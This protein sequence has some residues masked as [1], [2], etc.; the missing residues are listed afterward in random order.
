MNNLS[1]R[2]IEHS[3]DAG[4]RAVTLENEWLSVTVLPDKGA[5]IYRFVYKP[6][7]LDVLWK[8]PWG[9][10]PL[11]QGFQT[12]SSSEEAWLENYEGGWQEIFPNGGDACFYKGCHLNF[13]GEVS[14]LPWSYSLESS[15]GVASA[16]FYVSTFRSPFQMQ[17][18]LVLEKG[19]PLL[20]I[21]E[22]VTNIAEEEMHF[23]WGHHPAFGGEFLGSD[24]TIQL[25]GAVY[26]NHHVET[27]EL[28]RIAAGTVAPWPLI[29]GKREMVDLS[30]V[31]PPLERHY[32]FGYLR[33]LGEGWYA[34]SNTKYGFNF[35]LVWPLRVF[36]Y[37]WFWQ[38][39]RG[40]L[41]YP[42]HGRCRVMAIEP[43]SSVPGNGLEN[44][45]N[46]GTAPVLKPGESIEAELAAMCF[47]STRPIRSLT[48]QGPVT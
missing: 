36:P 2:A 42:W 19:Q 7:Q 28:S 39:L 8:S 29:P 41:G 46:A 9:L 24:C 33:D 22:R 1:C 14:T 48:L 6:R 40:S 45:I 31:P 25:P 47:E 30:I 21:F 4:I 16:Q 11:G 44:A 5:D 35:G 37:L 32:E 3:V 34:V 20:K 17:R 27:T 38:E 18:R 13:H 23:M 10:R 43:F 26:Q 15:P 12:T